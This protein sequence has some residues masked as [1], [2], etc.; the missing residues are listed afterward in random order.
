MKQS[1]HRMNLQRLEAAAAV[2]QYRSDRQTRFEKG[3]TV[4]RNG[5]STIGGYGFSMV[6]RYNG[7]RGWSI[8]LCRVTSERSRRTIKLS[9]HARGLEPEFSI[10][11]SPYYSL[12]HQRL[13]VCL[14]SSVVVI[15]V[16]GSSGAWVN[17]SQD[18]RWGFR[19]DQLRVDRGFK[20]KRCPE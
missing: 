14:R 7:M 11:Q 3:I 6:G 13:A 19:G 8:G 4:G 20:A 9:H 2:A 15:E 12:F 10:Q 17:C 18:R 5:R 16:E 1:P